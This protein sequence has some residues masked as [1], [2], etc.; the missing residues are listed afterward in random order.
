M[1]TMISI[2]AVLGTACT[3]EG[4]RRPEHPL[5]PAV[6][7]EQPDAIHP[8]AFTEITDVHELPDGRVLVADRR[9][10]HVVLLDFTTGASKQVGR[11][12][13]GPGEYRFPG[14]FYPQP[15]GTTLLNDFFTHR[16]LVLDDTGGT[17]DV[18]PFPKA[19]GLGIEAGS[20]DAR[21]RIYFR[22]R[23]FGDFDGP[24]TTG[25]VQAYPDSLAIIRWDPTS[26]TVDTAGWVAA[27]RIK[28]SSDGGGDKGGASLDPPVFTPGDIWGVA[29]DGAVARVTP[30]PYRIIWYGKDSVT[31]G[32][33]QPYS[34]LPVTEADRQAHYESEKGMRS[35]AVGVRDDGH[36]SIGEGPPV[37]QPGHREFA[38]TKPPFLFD[39]AIRVTPDGQVWVPR[40]RGAG[41]SIP[42]YDVF[43]RDG[44]KTQ[45]VKLRP[46]S[47]VIGFGRGAI[48]LIRADDDDVQHLE[49]F[50]R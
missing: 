20:Y 48:Y 1:R 4:S 35:I 31:V 26:G 32:L 22:S 23:P 27:P 34:P 46:S 16:F 24:R 15:N 38:A 28:L 17:G 18:V 7:L 44:R 50:R 42:R 21:G 30:D 25:R 13:S 39:A 5:Q 33:A 19:A 37:G 45:E 11:Q 9:N 12:G 3:R 49:R 6:A 41:D 43:D 10:K 29:P 40:A 36:T 2:L 8:A 47:W 14:Q